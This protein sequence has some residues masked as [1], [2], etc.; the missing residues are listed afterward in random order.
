[1][2]A[3]RLTAVAL[4]L[5]VLGTVCLLLDSIC[6]LLDSIRTAVRLPKEGVRL[7]DPGVFTSPLFQWAAVVGFAFLFAGFVLQGLALWRARSGRSANEV[8]APVPPVA[9]AQPNR[10]D[11]ERAATMRA[12]YDA[13]CKL[14]APTSTLRFTTLAAFFALNGLLLNVLFQ[15]QGAADRV[16][17]GI[18][19]FA[20]FA[21]GLLELRTRDAHKR[22]M[23]RGATL[24]NNENLAIPDG[25]FT[26][27][28]DRGL[29]PGHGKILIWIYFITVVLWVLVGLVSF[30]V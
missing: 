12:E 9:V 2:T 29:L 13:V 22:Q 16:I 10:S 23:Q 26:Q 7:C 11:P 6:L 1:M 28:R 25:L 14:V 30:C 8:M 18:G 19:S 4:G 3:A 27:E 5:Q 20:N 15:S 21:F 17:I 24:E